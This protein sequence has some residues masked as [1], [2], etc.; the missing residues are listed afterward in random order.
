MIV[1]Q[2]VAMSENR[3]IGIKNGMP[4]DIP[5]DMKFFKETTMG[6]I[7]IHGRKTYEALGYRP[8][9]K[10]LNVIVT[11]HPENIPPHKDIVIVTSIEEA[12]EYARSQIKEWGEEV[13]V[14]GGGEIYKLA[15]PYTDR[16]YLTL[17]HKKIEGDA[18]FPEF[19]TQIF[20]EVSKREGTGATPHT[21]YLYEKS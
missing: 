1:S 13:F 19:D 21:Y 4:W 20:K 8:L 3:V 14:S 16:I 12:L 18:F 10:R 11:R 6:H 9:P 15:M 17:V 2:I 5:E 7:V